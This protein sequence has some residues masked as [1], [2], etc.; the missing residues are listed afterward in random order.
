MSINA[1][2]DSLITQRSLGKFRLIKEL[3][4]GGMGVVYLAVDETLQREVAL[5]VL[6]PSFTMDKASHERLLREARVLA[7][8]RHPGVVQVHALDE[9]EGTSA[10]V[11]EYVEGAS[12]SSAMTEGAVAESAALDIVEQCLTVLSDCHRRG[13][14]HCDVKPSNILLADDGRVMLTDF[15]LASA[16]GHSAAASSSSATFIGTPKYAPPEAWEGGTPTPAWDVYACGMVLLELLAGKTPYDADSPIGIMRKMVATDAVPF[17]KL[18][19][20]APADLLSLLSSMLSLE[21]CSRIPSAEEALTSLRALR[22]SIESSPSAQSTLHSELPA[23]A[24]MR[25]PARLYFRA[26]IFLVVV[27]TAV[28]LSLLIYSKQRGLTLPPKPTPIAASTSNNQVKNEVVL[29]EKPITGFAPDHLAWVADHIVFTADW[30]NDTKAVWGVD[31]AT[32]KAELLV[33]PAPG[34][35]IQL[36]DQFHT[37]ERLV[38]TVAD[39][40]GRAGVYATGGTE[41]STQLLIEAQATRDQVRLLRAHEGSVYFTLWGSTSTPGL[42]VTDGTPG[43][44]RHLIGEGGDITFTALSFTRSGAAFLGSYDNRTLYYLPPEGAPAVFLGRFAYPIHDLITIGERAVVASGLFDTGA[45]LL[46][47]DRFPDTKQLLLDAMPGIESGCEHPWL[48]RF[49]DQVL[50]R[51]T[52]PEH[53][54]EPWITDGTP[55]GTFM[56]RDV[57]PGPAGSDPY[58]F[59][60]I[61]GGRAAFRALSTENGREVYVTDGTTGGTLLLADI[62]PGPESAEPYAFCRFKNGMLFSAYDPAHGEELWFTDGTTAGTVLVSQIFPGPRGAAPYGMLVAGAYAFFGATGPRN[63]RTM[64]VTDGTTAGTREFLAGLPTL[65]LDLP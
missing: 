26:A 12:L 58:R 19:P 29:A 50:F 34:S 47:V 24:S 36:D 6:Y 60:D 45:E 4:R 55:E 27:A 7:S 51:A 2:G 64:W 31:A 10:I 28:G 35:T 65:S 11:M 14:V 9:L 21:S 17:A 43:G 3:G 1:V 48:A 52:T 49:G 61:G 38:F 44:T 56:L 32:K 5:K 25:G 41:A 16:W 8:I 37:A 62:A 22:G 53:G 33:A 18:L 42:W 57:E 39:A 54:M 30:E 59:L 23:T 46:L 20:D 40:A 15:G 63:G 13:I